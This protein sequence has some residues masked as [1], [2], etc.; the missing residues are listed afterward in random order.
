LKNSLT[1]HTATVLWAGGVDPT[2]T[3][4]VALLKNQHGTEKQLERFWLELY[5]R[6]L[7]PIESLQELYLE[8]RRLISLACPNSVSESSE[9]LAINQFR[10]GL[11]KENMK[12]EVLNKNPMKFETALHIA[13]R[14]EAL[15]PEHSV[16]L[17]AQASSVAQRAWTSQRLYMMT[18]AARTIFCVLMRYMS[19]EPD[20]D[21][22]VK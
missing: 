1:G 11:S 13:M 14:C 4:L 9:M 3:E 19:H 15:E 16:P 2:T 6:K 20:L 7:K 12:I 18:K 8:I 5:T 22:A 17:E 21:T 10:T